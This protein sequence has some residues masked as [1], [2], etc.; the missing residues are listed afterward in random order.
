M[1]PKHLARLG[2]APANGNCNRRDDHAPAAPTKPPARASDLDDRD[3]CADREADPDRPGFHAGV[4]CPSCGRKLTSAR[5]HRDRQLWI[6]ARELCASASLYGLG[7]R[8]PTALRSLRLAATLLSGRA[9]TY[10]PATPRD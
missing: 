3:P 1:R 6:L 7:G 9:G 8:T 4:A 10:E 5:L 2:R